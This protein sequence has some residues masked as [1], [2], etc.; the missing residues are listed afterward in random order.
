[1]AFLAAYDP[2]HED[3][4]IMSGSPPPE[5]ELEEQGVG[6]LRSERKIFEKGSH[7]PRLVRVSSTGQ[8]DIRSNKQVES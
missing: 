8:I 2:A 4:D 7:S 6:T 1:M 3:W 5:Q